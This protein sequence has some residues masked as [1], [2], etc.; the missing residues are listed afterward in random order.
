MCVCIFQ[1]LQ[2]A[3]TLS[4]CGA[5][6]WVWVH[7]IT[8]FN[9][10]AGKTYLQIH[11]S[12]TMLPLPPQLLLTPTNFALLTSCLRHSMNYSMLL[13]FHFRKRCVVDDHLFLATP[14]HL[15]TPASFSTPSLDWTLNSSRLTRNR[16]LH[17]RSYRLDSHQSHTRPWLYSA[18]KI[19]PPVFESRA[20]PSRFAKL[21]SPTAYSPRSAST[22][23]S[24]TKNHPPSVAPVPFPFP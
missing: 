22:L 1:V 4:L 19:P 5:W 23:P 11:R 16:P 18:T 15:S 6:V 8:I 7:V 21:A 13:I 10:S 3:Q 9:I 12:T 17:L 14:R 2:I 24:P 20:T